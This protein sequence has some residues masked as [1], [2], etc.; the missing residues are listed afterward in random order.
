LKEP[1][2]AGGIE[3]S[4]L[5]NLRKLFIPHSDKSHRNAKN[6]EPRYTAGTRASL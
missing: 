5:L 6:A 3:P 1:V 2:P 4:V